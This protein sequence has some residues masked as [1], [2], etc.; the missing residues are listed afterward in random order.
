[1]KTPLIIVSVLAAGLVGAGLGLSRQ[2]PKPAAPDKT[3]DKPAAK[4]APS[5]VEQFVFLKGAWVGEEEGERSEEIWSGPSGNNLVGAFRW[6]QPSGKPAMFEVLAITA[7]DDGVFLRMH[8]YTAK[9]VGKEAA[10]KPI[11]CK[12]TA[13]ATNRAEFTNTGKDHLDKVIYEVKD[14]TLT[15]TVS[16]KDMDAL[17]F[18]L[19]KQ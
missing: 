3:V 19:K 7:E 16:F 11:T 10:D 14:T 6:L 5:P 8:H 9:L 17:K 4:P 13:S 15:I 1:M 12:L 2:E 18:S